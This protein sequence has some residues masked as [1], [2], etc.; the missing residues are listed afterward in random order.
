MGIPPRISVIVVFYDMKREAA[1]TLHTLSPSYQQ[2][3]SEFDYE[4]IAI[5]NG[6]PEPLKEDFV[7]SFGSNFRY[8]EYDAENGSPAMAVNVGIKH[9]QAPY[10]AM[11]V[12]GARMVSPGIIRATLDALIDSQA[13]S[14]IGARAFVC[15]LAWH[16]GSDV[17]NQSL[18]NGYDQSVEDELL[19][20]IDWR[21]DGYSLF[22]VSTLANSSDIGLGGGFPTECS[23]FAMSRHHFF[24]IGGF[25]RR[26]ESPGGGLVNHE[27]VERVFSVPPIDA[28]VLKGEGNF[29]QFHGGVATNVKP[30]HHPW[31]RF[32]R[33]YQRLMG[34]AYAGAPDPTP[35]YWGEVH[36]K[37][38]RFKAQAT[39]ASALQFA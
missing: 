14:E 27:F 15:S 31:E 11:I 23:W 22:E 18:L 13:K 34:R 1:R 8:V 24:E 3:V 38:E 32:H 26:F 30:E 4:V 17:Q 9:A 28:I 25:D 7:A 10:I 21:A 37:A 35:R 5:D 16:L 29:H 20:T 12:D 19:E 6:S 36:P 2:G 39:K 33:E